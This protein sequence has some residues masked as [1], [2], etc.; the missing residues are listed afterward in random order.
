MGV[1]AVNLVYSDAIKIHLNTSRVNPRQVYF[2]LIISYGMGYYISRQEKIK[3][4]KESISL[5]YF[6]AF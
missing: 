3:D 5:F 2:F 4:K 1:L 6:A